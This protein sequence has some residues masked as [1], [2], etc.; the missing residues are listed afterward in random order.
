MAAG[1]AGGG[2]MGAAIMAGRAVVGTSLDMSG[3]ESGLAKAKKTLV[4]WGKNVAVAGAAVAGLGGLIVA[5]IL[6]G[7]HSAVTEIT[8]VRKAAEQLGAGTEEVSALA[9]AAKKAGVDLD[10]FVTSGRHMQKVLSDAA[11]GDQGAADTL[12]KLGLNAKDLINLPL[13][14]QF[15][16]IADGIAALPNASDQAA[17]AMDVFGKAGAAMVPILRKGSAG[18]KE[19]RADAEDMG[20]IIS[21]EDAAKAKE[22]TKA[23]GRAKMAVEEFWQEVGSSV[24]GLAGPIK[25]ASDIFVSIVNGARRWAEANRPLVLSI[26]GVGAAIVAAGTALVAIGGFLAAAGV[27][28]GGFMTALTAVGSVLAFVFSPV[29]L[30]I[31]ALAVAGVAVAALVMEFGDLEEIGKTLGPVFSGLGDVFAETWGGIKDALAAGD[32]GLA[33]QIAVDGL[34]VIWQG[35][36]VGLQA[37]WVSFKGVFVDEWHKGVTELELAWN[38]FDTVLQTSILDVLSTISKEFHGFFADLLNMAASAAEA[39]GQDDFAKALRTTATAGPEVFDAAKREVARKG[40][41]EAKKIQDDA[42]AA[43]A[44]R[45]IDRAGKTQEQ[46]DKLVEARQKLADDRQKAAE[47]RAEADFQK[48]MQKLF[49]DETRMQRGAGAMAAIESAGRGSFGTFGNAAG[50][51][52]AT[53]A[54]LKD[55]AD[56]T[57]RAA[58]GIDEIKKKPGGIPIT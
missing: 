7:F 54:P 58:D 4:G 10:G 34:D 48:E 49:D 33:F 45:E 13:E 15:N 28:V 3:L 50:I 56:N 19:M 46:I 57:G 11:S 31:A 21:T 8:E 18:L 40:I 23:M 1:S 6:A 43:Q 52:G 30:G 39:I 53:V 32:L 25:E 5:P 20:A 24:L 38:D 29:G 27:A 2:G 44:E 55:I 51:F 22:Y 17:A 26:F 16:A 36:L 9:F 41:D 37:G 47:A 42:D 14:D 12:K 35:A